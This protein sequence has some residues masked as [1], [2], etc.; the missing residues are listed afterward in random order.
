MTQYQAG[1]WQGMINFNC[2]PVPSN[3]LKRSP[4]FTLKV[5]RAD[6]GPN[7]LPANML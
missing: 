2:A 6:V 1:G 7:G 3:R 4:I 5:V